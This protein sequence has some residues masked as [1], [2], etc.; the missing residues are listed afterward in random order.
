MVFIHH[1]E[2]S[3]YETGT[4]PNLDDNDFYVMFEKQNSGFNS[5]IVTALATNDESEKIIA[6][7]LEKLV[8]SKAFQMQWH[9]ELDRDH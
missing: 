8:I 9:F 5:S 1:R 6:K 4:Q 2:L 3:S 7:E